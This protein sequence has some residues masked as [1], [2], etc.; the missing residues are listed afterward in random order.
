M[1]GMSSWESFGRDLVEVLHSSLLFPKLAQSFL[2]YLSF[3]TASSEP[4]NLQHKYIKIKTSKIKPSKLITR[5]IDD[6]NNLKAWVAFQVVL[7]LLSLARPSCV[8]LTSAQP[9]N[10]F[11]KPKF[12]GPESCLCWLQTCGGLMLLKLTTKINLHSLPIHLKSTSLKMHYLDT[13]VWENLGDHKRP[14]PS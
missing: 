6:Q 11:G 5:K 9:Q 8:S 2:C 14:K 10:T 7:C 3:A 12:Y 4:Q 1:I 13:T